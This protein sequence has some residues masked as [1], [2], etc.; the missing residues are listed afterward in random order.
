MISQSRILLLVVWACFF[1]AEGQAAKTK[2]VGEPLFSAAHGFFEKPFALQI[3]SKT[4]GARIYFTTNGLSP[5]ERNGTP[6]RGPLTISATTILRASAYAAGREH[7]EAVTGSYI[8]LRDVVL[9]TGSGFPTNWGLNQGKPVPADYE[10]D[11]EITKSSAY[12][13]QMLPALQ[14]LP[15]VSIVMPSSDLFDS[16]KGI[17]AN[18]RETGSDWERDASLELIYP[19]GQNGFHINCGIR[20]QGG[21]NR[22]PEESPKHS[23]RVVFRKNYGPGK[24]KFPI[25][26]GGV[27]EFDTLILRGGCNN[28]WLH[29]H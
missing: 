1:C 7:S 29:W 11:P 26:G 10:M 24:L 15:A 16:K 4:A 28:T 21:W 3:T 18:P 20:I 8:F 17:Y 27:D 19:E 2:Q 12:R 13:D 9:Q 25:F 5:D 6:Y 14:A 22:R 23:F